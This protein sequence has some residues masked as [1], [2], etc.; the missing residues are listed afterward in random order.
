[1]TWGTLV[2]IAKLGEGNQ[3]PCDGE[4]AAFDQERTGLVEG[5]AL[6]HKQ[7][8]AGLRIPHTQT[9]VALPTAR[10]YLFPIW[11]EGAACH[12]TTVP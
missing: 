2:W 1:M 10:H 4:E 8:L 5:C 9:G 7:T 11:C 6:L 12:C 3:R